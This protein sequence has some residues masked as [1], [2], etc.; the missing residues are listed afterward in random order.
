MP[1]IFSNNASAV[2]TVAVNTTF[3]T[4]NV[5][6]GSK[7]PTPTGGDFFTLALIGLNA[8]GQEASWEIVQCT[9]RTGNA[10]TVTRAQES[11]VAAAWG[12][13]TRAELRLTAGFSNTVASHVANTSNPHSVTKTQVGLGNV[14]NTADSAKPV[15]TAQA[16]AIGLKAN[17]ASPVFTGNVTGLGVAT[18]TSFNAITGLASTT[19]A[20]TGVAEVGTSTTAARSDHVHEAP[21]TVTGNA[22]TATVLQT[23][24]TIAGVSFN[25]SANIALPYANLTGLPTLGTAAAKNIP[26]TGNASATEVVYGTDTRL[27]NSR[28]ANGGNAATVTTNANL[29]GPITS[30]GNATAVASQTGTGSTFVMSNSPTLVTPAL[31]VAS[32]TSF[33]SI[34]GLSSTTPVVASVAAVGTGTTTA[35]GD[36][37]HPAQ[38]SVTGNAGTATALATAR[39]IAGVS[40][41]G[42]ADIAIPFANLTS[43]PT[44]LTGYGITDAYTKAEVDSFV[45]GLDFKASV[46]AVSTANITLSGTQTIDTVALNA[47]DRV[48]VT[49]QTTTST[50]GI[51][52]VAAGAWTRATDAD[53]SA[54]VT[55]GMYC[56]VSEGATFA[57]SGWV[58]TT[59]DSIVLGTTGLIFTQ[60][61]GLGQV[62]AGTG[63]TKVGNTL[64]VTNTALGNLSGTNT[65]DETGAGIRTKLGITTL[66]GSNT[67]DQVIPTTLPASDVSA[68][69]KAATKPAYTATE[70]GLGN[71]TNESKGT[72]FSSPFFSG[73]ATVTAAGGI[74]PASTGIAAASGGS[75]AFE[76]QAQG[77]GATAGAAFMTFH[78]PGAHA[79][80]IGLDTDNFW[81]VGGWYM[82]AVAYKL[83]HEGSDGAGSGLDADLLDGQH[84]SYY[85]PLTSPVFAGIPRVPALYVGPDTDLYLYESAAGTMTVR[86]GASGSYKYFDFGAD[87]NFRINAGTLTVSSTT[88]VTNLNADQLDGLDSTAFAPALLTGYVSG[89]GTVA[90]TDTVVQAVN[91][92]NGNI[93]TKQ[94]TLVSAN[95][96]KTINGASLLGSGNVVVSAA[97]GMTLLATL[98]PTAA[99][100]V[101]FLSAFSGTYDNYLIVGTGI[102]F[103]ADEGLNMRLAVAGA[104]DATSSYV[105]LFG[106][107]TNSSSTATSLQIPS[108]ATIRSGGKGCNFDIRVLN[109]N[110]TSQFKSIMSSIM[111]NDT[112]GTSYIN[113]EKRVAY[114]AANAV[115]GFRLFGTF[116]SNFAAAGTI[117]VY[118]YANT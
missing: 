76:A 36:H 63:L 47:G 9:A 8:N 7:F 104:A 105:Q 26:A 79:A 58:L 37:V 45:T 29:T 15:S 94:D 69:A 31:G 55:G 67:G 56:F 81:K 116:G 42:S 106:Q 11:T 40:F 27:T 13:G 32:G 84:G 80:H 46:R 117:R 82:G 73:K 111:W 89:A 2:L 12:V 57:D 108:A 23:A 54:E 95:N 62:T 90:A 35:R 71:V 85:A 49:G 33:N 74:L 75:G 83:W 30:S 38:T 19:P 24:R 99:A 17:I 91:K 107:D 100:N 78:R 118:G 1:Q 43:K 68:W 50:N 48:L 65:G 86:S 3:T 96:I 109:A 25:G 93:A 101:D 14:D 20:A 53:S 44:T 21:T 115:T 103:A 10:L 39:N 114:I 113:S 61:N 60:F 102:K 72:M 92:L 18:G 22:G 64:S 4:L 34:T 5:D 88:K 98:T 28:T 51:Y 112:T 16:T 110:N 97:S 41:N 87:G 77:T 6:D 59:N 52:V 70:V 66:S